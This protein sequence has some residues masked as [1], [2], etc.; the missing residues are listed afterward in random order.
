MDEMASPFFSRL[1]HYYTPRFYPS[2]S[3][4]SK[5][6]GRYQMIKANCKINRRMTF[7][8]TYLCMPSCLGTYLQR[9]RALFRPGRANMTYLIYSTTYIGTL[10]A[11]Q[12]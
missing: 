3:V 4:S 11:L 5:S 1:V 12:I 7:R 6:K 8:P 9:R 10:V 2:I